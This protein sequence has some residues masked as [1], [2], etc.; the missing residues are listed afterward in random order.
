V[1][2]GFEHFRIRSI[3]EH[4]TCGSAFFYHEHRPKFHISLPSFGKGKT[5]LSIFQADRS[6]CDHALFVSSRPNPFRSSSEL[7]FMNGCC[8]YSACFYLVTC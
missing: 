3:C 8:R 1:C 7:T 2:K 6:L 4:K 5:E